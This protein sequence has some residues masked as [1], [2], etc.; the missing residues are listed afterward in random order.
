LQA[1]EAAGVNVPVTG[2]R[3]IVY[4]LLVVI[5]PPVAAAAVPTSMIVSVI[6]PAESAIC[7]LLTAAVTH[8][9]ACAATAIEMTVTLAAP[10]AA[11]SP[12]IA[13][14]MSIVSVPAAKGNS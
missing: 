8:P 9:L 12:R 3:W 7:R 1:S 6:A 11:I 4:V 10:R 2:N 13:A 14:V 5:V